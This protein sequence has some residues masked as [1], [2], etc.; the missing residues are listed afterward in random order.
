MYLVTI[1][2]V[3]LNK[4]NYWA[5]YNHPPKIVDAFAINIHPKLQNF[6]MGN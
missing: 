5:N 6:T 1:C 3:L 4:L 2:C